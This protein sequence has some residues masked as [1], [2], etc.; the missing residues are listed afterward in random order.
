ML[1]SLAPPFAAVT[2]GQ[3]DPLA[4]VGDWTIGRSAAIRILKQTHPS[5]FPPGSSSLPAPATDRLLPAAVE[6]LI[7]QRVVYEYLSAERL[8]AGPAEI[9]LEL[10]QLKTTLAD[11]GLTVDQFLE[12]EGISQRELE[13]EID[14]KLSWNRH[15]R[16]IITDDYLEQHYLS[17]RPRFDGSEIRVAHLFLP[18]SDPAGFE[19]AQA[20]AGQILRQLKLPDS[21]PDWMAWDEAVLKHSAAPTRNKGGEVGWIGYADPM[22]PEFSQAAFQLTAGQ[23]SPP[24]VSPFG[25]HLI[26]C[27]ETKPGKIGWKDAREAVQQDAAKTLFDRIHQ[28][29][30]SLIEITPL[31]LF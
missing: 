26:K 23:I 5:L 13:Y 4:T 27:L 6:A 10:D 14:W 15:L 7:A 11:Q 18:A 8:V 29:H 12:T 25:V 22:P 1:L 31:S 20:Q 21:H 16:R 30:R 19:S 28:Q 9:Q 17:R 24:V 3:A 2:R